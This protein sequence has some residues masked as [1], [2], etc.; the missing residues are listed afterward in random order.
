MDERRGRT[1]ERERGRARRGPAMRPAYRHPVY[2][3]QARRES[4]NLP[5]VVSIVVIVAFL[6]L[7]GYIGLSWAT[8]PGRLAG[9]SAPPP[10]TPAPAAPVLAASPLPSPSTAPAE[11]VYV[12]QAGDTP[13]DIAARFHVRVQDL[14]AANN[15]SDPRTLQ[16]GQ[17][18][19]IPVPQ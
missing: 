1:R 10:P 13:A 3:G 9:L 5:Y 8:G 12:V 15:I 6:L 19:K 2:G 11:Q 17:R 4:N 18:L 14:L 16:V 7:F